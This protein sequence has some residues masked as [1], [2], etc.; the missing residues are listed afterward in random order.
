MELETAATLFITPDNITTPL[1]LVKLNGSDQRPCHFCSKILQ[2]NE[3]RN[4]VGIHILKARRDVVDLVAKEIGADACGWCGR[5]GCKTQL[6][7]SK[8]TE[9]VYQ[10]PS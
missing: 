9:T 10:Y 4:H 6:V 2:I 1:N 5:D 8:N 7:E 3:M